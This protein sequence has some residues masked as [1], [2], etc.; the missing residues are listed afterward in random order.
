MFLLSG[1]TSA[2]DRSALV[3]WRGI[4]N[5]IEQWSDTVSKLTNAELRKQSLA[6]RY[7]VLSGKPLDELIVE[8][9]SLVRESAD[10]SI[11][12]R[13]YPVQLLGG[14]AMHFGSIAVMQTGEGKT[15]TATLPMYL[16]AL[17][18]R[19]AL[20]ATANDYL[21]ARDAD[22]MKPV[23]EMLGMSVGVVQS[24]TIRTDRQSAYA[25]DVTYSTA[26]EIGFDFLRDRLFHRRLEQG[27]VGL[28]AGMVGELKSDGSNKPVQREPNFILVDEA[29]SIL[30][31]EA[32]TPLIVSA[33]PD[34][35]VQAKLA[36]YQWAARYVDRYLEGEH[37]DVDPTSKQISL[38]SAGRKLVRQLPQPDLLQQ[39]PALDIYAQVEQAIYVERNYVRDRHYVVREGEVVIVDEFTGR[40]A[41]GRKWRSGLHQAIEA[42]EAIEVS[43]E[44]G[45]AA[46]ITIQDLFLRYPRLAGMTGTAANSAA[47]LRKIY[48]VRVVNIPTNR[49]PK[50]VQWA[51]QV[52]GTAAQKWN[53]IADEIETLHRSGRPVL[54]GTR[55]I[56][57]SETLSQILNQRGIEHEVLN[58]RQLSREAGIV[59]GAGQVS[60]VTVATNMAGRG[61]D[62][63]ISSAALDLGG[64]HVICTELHESARIDR[65]LIGRCGRQGDPGTFR[66]FMSLEDDLLDM[67]LGDK[68]AGKLRS[69]HDESSKTLAR[70]AALFLT[71]QRRIER[72]HFHSRK[73]LLHQESQRQEMQ[74]EMGQDPYLDTAGA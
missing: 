29:D 58:A 6:L 39:T 23:Y 3:K 67:G 35:I 60:R 30:I 40:L 70:F 26:K 71:A 17:S 50:R 43:I 47:E 2:L 24:D 52:F 65:Q 19:G 37:Y 13:H 22:L 55:S 64:L 44:T 20:L 36:L 18:G 61:T 31:D 56:D 1:I 53:A 4:A 21:A 69:Y 14:I 9:F 15:L 33:A 42:R 16:A 5:R 51:N 54:V 28:I 49:P 46:R 12:M 41:E 48:G 68:R 62:I 27:H 10:R 34:E 32:R 72:R 57:K 38:K 11:G 74:R 8:A 45:E 25:C 66:Q 73:M 7:D 63:K 59:S